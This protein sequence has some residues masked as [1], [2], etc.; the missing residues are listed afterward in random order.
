MTTARTPTPMKIIDYMSRKVI[1]TIPQG[2]LGLWC[3]RQQYLPYRPII[4]GWIVIS[5][6]LDAR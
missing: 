1:A 3:R 2:E 6:W 4:G 5:S